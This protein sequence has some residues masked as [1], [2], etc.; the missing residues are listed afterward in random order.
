MYR[1]YVYEYPRNRNVYIPNIQIYSN[2]LIDINYTGLP[3]SPP[4]ADLYVHSGSSNID[5]NPM[6]D[7][8]VAIDVGPTIVFAITATIFIGIILYL[9]RSNRVLRRRLEEEYGDYG[10]GD[11]FGEEDR[12]VTPYEALDDSEPRTTDEP[13][14]EE[15]A[16]DEETQILIVENSES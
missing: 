8:A 9:L 3:C 15:E 11:D 5:V 14:E 4:A 1:R 10:N 7:D 13:G 6:P 12:I 16:E 2:T